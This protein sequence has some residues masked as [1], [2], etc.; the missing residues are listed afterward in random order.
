MNSCYWLLENMNLPKSS[1]LP[2]QMRGNCEGVLVV[3]RDGT[4]V[5]ANAG[6][7]ALA[8]SP[9]PTQEWTGR[10]FIETIAENERA[11]I[12]AAWEA[13]LAHGTPAHLAAHTHTGQA[14]TLSFIEGV[15]EK[16]W[17]LV[18]YLPTPGALAQ[19]LEQLQALNAV[20][21]ALGST[22]D[23]SEVLELMF[24][25][26]RR[27]LPFD[28]ATVW[29]LKKGVYK[30]AQIKGAVPQEYPPNFA[31]QIPDFPAHKWL[32]RERRPLVIPDVHQ[33]DLWTQR[34]KQKVS[35]WIGVPLIANDTIVGML[36]LDS[37]TANTYT[38]QDGDL[39]FAFGQQA[40][41]AIA[42]ARRY[43]EEKTRATRL[44]ALY[45]VG[46]AI[47]RPDVDDIL[48]LVHHYVN[49]L[50]DALT[51]LV[52]LYDAETNKLFFRL[53]Y[54]RGE[55]VAPFT[56]EIEG[57]LVGWV[58]EHR[59]AVVLNDT[60]H[61]EPPVPMTVVDVAPRSLIIMPMIASG[62]PVGVLSVQSYEPNVYSEED[63]QFLDAVASQT[64]VAVRNAQL[65]AQTAHRLESLEAL[66]KTGLLLTSTPNPI[67]AL[68]Q[69]AQ[70]AQELVRADAVCVCVV[71]ETGVLAQA[72]Q[73]TTNTDPPCQ[74]CRDQSLNIYIGDWPAC[75]LEAVRGPVTQQGEPVIL[76]EVQYGTHEED[77]LPPSSVAG[78]PLKHTDEILGAFILVYHKPHHFRADE[79]H[80][81]NVLA[82]YMAIAVETGRQYYATQRRFHEVSVLYE[83]S[84]QATHS[85]NSEEVLNSVVRTLHQFFDC[86]A[87]SIALVE[88][89]TDEIVI[90]TSV[91]IEERW[92]E[93]ARLK[94]GEG[95][96]GQVVQTGEPIY[97]E[98][99]QADPDFIFFDP[100]LRSLMVVPLRHGENVIGTLA[101]DSFE[102]YAF[103]QQDQRLLEIAAFQ[104]AVAI[105]NARL[106]EALEDRA[107]RLEAAN[108]ELESLDELRNE[109]VANVSHDLRSPLTFLK[110][111]IGLFLD[112]AMGP[113]T[114]EQVE[115]LN[116]ILEKTDAVGRLIDDIMSMERITPDSLQRNVYDFND[117][118]TRAVT[119]AKFGMGDR[120]LEIKS[121]I[122]DYPNPVYVDRT[123]V[124]QVLANLIS[125]A[126][127]FTPDDGQITVNLSRSW[128]DSVTLSVK[129]TGIGIAPD[130][131]KRVFER[132]YRVDR[133]SKES[134]G[135]GL[136][137][138]KLIVEAHGGEIWLEESKPGEGSTFAFS[139][140]LHKASQTDVA[141]TD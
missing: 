31:K 62:E 111:Y 14:V 97:V 105:V 96:S 104:V 132:F 98:D 108:T 135:L 2:D 87:V 32:M 109:L 74:D 55:R 76:T 126:V 47:S 61:E 93:A 128:P 8:G 20:W 103:S 10:H 75:T 45:Q 39:A 73:Q 44:Q 115:A 30:L 11:R 52:A 95:I 140:P 106:Y 22:L 90:H 65:F 134:T 125:N 82:D 49:Q 117:I 110:G 72:T 57:L 53:C 1:T 124:N 91:G 112:E 46:L 18:I 89:D 59:Q 99:A 33:S 123:R 15:E 77:D 102:P 85:L 122:P 7:V 23:I 116:V 26:L 120:Q 54:D 94:V 38:K 6:F 141:K 138:A 34:N 113:I 137:I 37:Y 67:G 136:S 80:L 101:L 24:Q 63:V 21:Q 58:I 50:M 133:S 19:R 28:V 3:K 119:D 70:T 71:D 9:P 12:R 107:A 56:R 36:T 29:L 68:E 43:E 121:R 86:R 79:M 64:A 129:D 127:K 4:V 27:V 139:L 114:K 84:K 130:T 48:E 92:R 69:I 25:H 131:Q 16:A 51:F 78:F 13:F 81:L 35:S 118:V 5:S 60:Q 42:N 88:E 66:Q 40:A 100:N 83:V 17:V 41:I